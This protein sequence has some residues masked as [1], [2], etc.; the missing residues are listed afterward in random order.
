MKQFII[1]MIAAIGW[2][3]SSC[4]H[5]NGN[6]GPWF[7]TWKL[8]AIT[9]DGEI[10]NEYADNDNLVWKFQSTV[11]EM[12]EI[13]PMHVTADHF[14]TWTQTSDRTVEMNFTYHD[15]LNPDG[16]PYYTPPASSHLPRGVFVMDILE[17]TSSKMHL[18][19]RANDGTIYTYYLKKW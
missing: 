7:G 8:N 10:D 18:Q 15:G 5:N 16:Y 1:I 14:G 4:T 3:L 17:L 2:M 6:I 11:I 9:I 19:Y 13:L 12:Q